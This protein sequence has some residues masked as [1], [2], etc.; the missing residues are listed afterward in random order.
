[1]PT[2]KP[3]PALV[4]PTIKRRKITDYLPA[5]INP[6]KSTPRGVPAIVNSLHQFGSGRS[7]VVDRD[8]EAIGGSH[9]IQA[10]IDAG[11]TDVIE[12]ESNG[13][14][15]I[16]HKRL[17]LDL[18]TDARARGLQIAD[19][20]TSQLGYT[21]DEEL[22]AEMLTQ[23]GAEDAKFV[24]AAGFE[25]YDVRMLMNRLSDPDNPYDE[26]VGMPEF[27]HDDLTGEAAF[28]IRV[29]LKD[30]DDLAAFGR[31]LGKDLTG[32]KFVWFSKQPIGDL[33]EVHDEPQP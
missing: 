21:A 26:W 25:D 30:A 8:G 10:A 24:Q 23:I 20:R 7:I 17:D 1:M 27:E 29:F 11:I 16:V 19:N 33:F 22:L 5:E 13:N 9:T 12:I 31:L 6:N 4:E 18:T 32:K 28:T 3:T 14:A 2:K 15:I